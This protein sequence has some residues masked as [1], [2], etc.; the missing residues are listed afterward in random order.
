MERFVGVDIDDTIADYI[1]A[2][3]RRY[4]PAKSYVPPNLAEMFPRVAMDLHFGIIHHN[5]F[6]RE[7]VPMVGASDALRLIRKSWPIRYITSRPAPARG[8]TK[9]WLWLNHFPGGRMVFLATRQAKTQYLASVGECMIAYVDDLPQFL[10]A[11]ST[12]EGRIVIAY[13]R[14]WNVGLTHVPRAEEWKDIPLMIA[15]ARGER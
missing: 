4:G 3:E 1:G 11:A 9:E 5:A 6:L 12:E 15:K 7:L 14:P 10:G 2:M 8:V 13:V